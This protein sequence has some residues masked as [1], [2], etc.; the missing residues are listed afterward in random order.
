MTEHNEKPLGSAFLSRMAR[1]DDPPLV[2]RV[3]EVQA[4]KDGAAAFAD[5][6]A[7]G[8]TTTL[9]AERTGVLKDA[10]TNKAILPFVTSVESYEPG[11]AIEVER[12]LSLSEDLYLADHTFIHAPGVKPVS[13]CLP[14]LPMTMSLEAIAEV[15]ACLCPGRGLIGFEDVK[16]TRW[17]E[18]ADTDALTLRIVAKVQRLDDQRDI[19]FIEALI[20]TEGQARPAISAIVLFCGHYSNDLSLGISDLENPHPFPLSA[21]EVYRNRYM[22]HGPRL[23]CMRGDIAIGEDGAEGE[24]MVRS[25]GDLFLSA[26]CPQLLT[27]PAVLD[28]VGQIVGLW[29]MERDLYVFPIGLAKLEIYCPTPS[30]GTR[31]PVRVQITRSDIKRVLANIEIE[32]GFGGV[33]M[34]IKEWAS[35]K[36]RWQR[37]L[38]DFRR[39]PHQYLLGDKAPRADLGPGSVCLMIDLNEIANFDLHMLARYC[40]SLQ[41]AVT[42]RGHERIP[43]RQ[44]QW[45]L[46]RIVAKD[47]V[48]RWVAEQTGGPLL[49]PAAVTIE[50]D[51][52]G[53]PFVT[54]LSGC[55]TP[56]YLSI[57][58][59][60]DRAI[61]VAHAEAVGVDIERIAERDAG[62]VQA[63]TTLGERSMIECFPQSE[64]HSWLTRLWCAKEASS[65]LRGTGFR[66]F[67]AALEA[68]EILADGTFDIRDKAGASPIRVTTVEDR[69]FAIAYASEMRLEAGAEMR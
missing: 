30:A 41:E 35:W 16:A 44:R 63:F 1:I 11:I 65:K 7:S 43:Q 24:F 8:E 15:A 67:P 10:M 31:V 6:A 49:H 19:S 27:D 9:G 62:C 68:M 5:R 12:R 69:G 37:R 53:R 48:R 61:A 46:G 55:D 39:L 40:L 66:Q 17:I 3:F 51:E 14:V 29:A 59:S 50:S 34:R 52:L 4:V 28:A 38:V 64:H 2:G 57:A 47:A 21:E 13:A 20:Y 25:P 56:P 23:Q 33:W 42:F 45:L 26:P 32:D 58:H 36:F 22:F 60:E 18:L 54:A